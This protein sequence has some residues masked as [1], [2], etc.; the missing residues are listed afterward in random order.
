MFIWHTERDAPVL[1]VV[2]PLL[3]N[4]ARRGRVLQG[5]FLHM[6]KVILQGDSLN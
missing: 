3:G 1:R 2:N 5:A 6:R 4:V